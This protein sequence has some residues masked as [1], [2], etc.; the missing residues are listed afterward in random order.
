[1]EEKISVVVYL[2]KGRKYLVI[3]RDDSEVLDNKFMTY[4]FKALSSML[5]GADVEIVKVSDFDM[6]LI[7]DMSESDRKEVL[8]F[9]KAYKSKNKKDKGKSDENFKA[10]VVSHLKSRIEALK[11]TV[12]EL[13]KKGYHAESWAHQVVVDELGRILKTIEEM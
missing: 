1:M 12:D 5:V 7:D 10:K 4:K 2:I 11:C 9:V 8:D 13:N 3:A 6:N